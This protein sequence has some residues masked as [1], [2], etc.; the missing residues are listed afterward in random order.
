MVMLKREKRVLAEFEMQERQIDFAVAVEEANQ[1]DFV[2]VVELFQTFLVVEQAVRITKFEVAVV[3][4][5]QIRKFVQDFVVVVQKVMIERVV[6][7]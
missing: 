1:K 6:Q 7:R 4:E 3:E 2:V 5:L